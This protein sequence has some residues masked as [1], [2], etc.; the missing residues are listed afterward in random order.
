MVEKNKTVKEIIIIII[1]IAITIGGIIFVKSKLDK[2]EPKK[3]EPKEVKPTT[4]PFEPKEVTL[5]ND[6]NVD[7]IKM[8]NAKANKSNYLLSPYNIEVALNL[9][10]EGAD[11][12]TKD[13]I[14]KIV[15]VR[16][17]ND[18]TVDGK[19]GVANGVFIK[20][21]YKN[22]VKDDYYNIM[23]TK[24]NSDIIYDDFVNPEKIN[25]WVKDKTWN[26]IEKVLD[27]VDE[28]FIMGL[29][30]ALAID[31]KWQSEFECD[32]TRSEEFTKADNT[33][34]NTEMMHD[35]YKYGSVKYIKTDDAEGIVLPYKKE[36]NSNVELEFIGIL[37]NNDVDTYVN[38]LTK[39]KINNLIDSEKPASDK[40][41]VHLSL[42][43]FTYDYEEKK[44][45]SVLM[46]MGIKDVF[47]PE[48]ANLKNMVEI[49]GKNAYVGT[50]IHKT[51]IELNETGTKAAAVTYFGVEGTGIMPQ[52]DY[53][54][55]SVIFNKPF[56]YMIRE[57][58]T[59]E[60][61]FFGSVYEPNTWKASTCKES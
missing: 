60:I 19:I 50:A 36:A 15:P 45:G 46:N 57:K 3:E 37:P 35:T 26:M 58:N 18:I 40:L 23:K 13:E 11:G 34:M 31:V 42:P 49:E 54:E 16:N 32:A 38:S 6:F 48:K 33:K 17:I 44:L 5:S 2:E 27:D 14:D 8:F 22:N 61:L 1:A 59:G 41:H 25:N 10:R 30:S 28:S 21:A 12:N 7:I 24:Y 53:E 52:D 55:V 9:L 51:H 56:I 4:T 39:E 29:A 20:N 43:R 47:N